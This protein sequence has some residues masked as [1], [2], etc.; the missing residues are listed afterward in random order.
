MCSA[1]TVL[2]G[3]LEGKTQFARYKHRLGDNISMYFR[4]IGCEVVEWIH[5]QTGFL[6]TD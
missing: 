5:G 3:K 1:Y 6:S 2:V 4:E